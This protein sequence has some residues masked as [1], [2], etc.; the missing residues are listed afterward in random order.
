MSD[1]P[2]SSCELNHEFQKAFFALKASR[3]E[4]FGAK[5]SKIPLGATE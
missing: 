3:Q 1:S 5:A 2:P 4:F